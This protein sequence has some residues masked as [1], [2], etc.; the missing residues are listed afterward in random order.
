VKVVPQL[1]GV[2]S[3]AFK[4]VPMLATT[5]LA[6]LT[7]GAPLAGLLWGMQVADF[8]KDAWNDAARR[9]RDDRDVSDGQAIAAAVGF[10]PSE[11]VD[12][13]VQ[14]HEWE[15][16]GQPRGPEPPSAADLA[17]YNRHFGGLPPAGLT[18]TQVAHAVLDRGHEE[19]L[20]DRDHLTTVFVEGLDLRRDV[21][22]LLVPALRSGRDIPGF[23]L[24]EREL[25]MARH[26][27]MR[28]EALPIQEQEAAREHS[29]V[30]TR[31]D[32][33][34]YWELTGGAPP[35]TATA[36]DVRRR[37]DDAQ[38][39]DRPALDPAAAARHLLDAMEL[40]FDHPALARG[41]G[42]VSTAAELLE[43]AMQGRVIVDRAVVGPDGTLH[44]LVD[45]DRVI[46]IH[47]G[48]A[49]EPFVA[50]EGAIR[51]QWDQLRGGSPDRA[52]P[53]RTEL[54]DLVR[55]ARPPDP[56][57]AAALGSH[58]P[59]IPGRR[60]AIQ[61]G[62]DAGATPAA[63]TFG[64]EYGTAAALGAP[65]AASMRLKL[66]RLG[67]GDRA[68]AMVSAHAALDEQRATAA[69]QEASPTRVSSL[70]LGQ[71]LPPRWIGE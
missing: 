6:L 21:R 36:R 48:E 63:A 3:P 59:E 54:H 8:A 42:Q 62:I 22:D 45:G 44:L 16:G 35:R 71:Q 49:Y 69:A 15:L 58:I 43:Q 29:D 38:A 46:S 10:S 37:I 66:D 17:A 9:L 11:A 18:S 40:E 68:G 51:Q 24:L 23:N 27:E 20:A 70:A 47:D 5:S 34:S 1:R 26:E 31:A 56:P 64:Y 39:A 30:K 2:A 65:G 7:G 13:L 53:G 50:S 12:R 57:T 4:H 33:A 28:I 14:H 61:R 55:Q 60:L 32:I 41:H 67:A 52:Y 19:L 25:V